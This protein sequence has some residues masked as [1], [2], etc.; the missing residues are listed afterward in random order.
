MGEQSAQFG[1]DASQ[2][3][4]FAARLLNDVR[5]IERMQAENLFEKGVRRIGAE[6]EFC[7]VDRQFRP[8]YRGPEILA[9]I[10]ESHFTAEVARYTLEIN[11][12]PQPLQDRAFSEM[13]K[14]LNRLLTHAAHVARKFDG[15]QVVLAGILPSIGMSELESRFLSPAPRYAQIQERIRELR[16]GG[17]IELAIQGVDDLMMRHDNILFEACNTSF[18]V[19]LQIEPDDFVDSYNWAQAISGPVLALCTNSPLLFGRE[20][21][22]ETRIALFQQSVDTRTRDFGLRQR[23]ARVYFGNRWI[24]HSLAEIFQEDIAR[25]PLF[26]STEVEDSLE[27]L[28]R[29]EVPRLRALALHNG[30]IWKWNRPCFGSNGKI[31]HLRIENRYLPAGPTTVDEI[32]NA[33]FWVGLM[34]GMP[35]Q[36]RRIW[37]KMDFLEAKD[38]FLRAAQ[39][40]LDVELAWQGKTRSARRMILEE[41]L[42]IAADGLERFG[43]DGKDISRYLGVIE[44]RAVT[45]MT[46][47]RWLKLSLRNA[48]PSMELLQKQ[49]ALTAALWKKQRSGQPVGDWKIEPLPQ[50]KGPILE[51]RVDLLM[52][53]D[54]ITVSGDDLLE[55]VQRIMDWRGLRHVPVENSRG[56]ICGIV[57]RN[58][59]DRFCR[60]HNCKDISEIWT[61]PG[62]ELMVAQLMIPD[63]AVIS[64]EMTAA[65]AKQIMIERGIG[66]LPVVRDGKLVGLITKQDVIRFEEKSVLQKQRAGKA[67]TP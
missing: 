10:N 50:I 62:Q 18:Q 1:I 37:E 38:N 52:S 48:D 60:E 63:P 56:E 46:G 36:Y 54:L 59:I 45:R 17:D 27:V 31:A 22:A 24:R 25:Y 42:P 14:Q 47:S 4:A 6:Q 58:D 65:R 55:M 19:H 28:A 8:S 51:E 34:V 16:G 61:P 21:W 40:G 32:A 13:E 7:V 2:R 57:T 66:C 29:G 67:G 39:H 11:L 3:R 49:T 41:L 30:T 33:A 23:Q 43:V 5:A 9:A 26:L 44:H 64:P 20:L 12:D 15:N 53:T 35:P